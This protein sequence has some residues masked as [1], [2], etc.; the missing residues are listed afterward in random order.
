MNQQPYDEIVIRCFRTGNPKV[1]KVPGMTQTK[2]ER[3]QHDVWIAP[4]S[5]KLQK[6]IKAKIVCDVC[7]D[8][9]AKPGEILDVLPLNNDQLGDIQDA[10]WNEKNK[11]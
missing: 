6:Q 10:T 3:C 9:K 5:V 11:N 4:S 8:L 7:Q 2:C 1:L